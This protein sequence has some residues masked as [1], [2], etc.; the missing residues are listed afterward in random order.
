MCSSFKL[1][2]CPTM[3]S[4]ADKLKH[5]NDFVELFPFGSAAE[6][7]H[8]LKMGFV[9]G[10]IIGRFAKKTEITS[11]VKKKCL[12]QK[13]YT[14][15]ARHKGFIDYANLSGLTVYTYLPKKIVEAFIPEVKDVLYL[16]SIDET[17]EH[18]NFSDTALIDWHDFRDEYEL[19]I[20]IRQGKKVKKFRLPVIYYHQSDEETVKKVMEKA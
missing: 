1:G 18:L 9:D 11:V 8:Y 19:M 10:T 12:Q 4:I 16:A 17:V 5:K 3:A 7:L 2:F 13:G 14:L 20:P 6:A 15:I